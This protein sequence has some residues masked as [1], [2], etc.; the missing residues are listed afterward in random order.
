M[1]EQ[2]NEQLRKEL[3]EQKEQYDGLL[4]TADHDREEAEDTAATA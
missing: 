1:F 2:D 3:R 4:Q